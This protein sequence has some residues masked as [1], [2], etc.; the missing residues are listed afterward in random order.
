[1]ELSV[2]D[3]AKILLFGSQLKKQIDPIVI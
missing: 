1:M 2:D 3:Q